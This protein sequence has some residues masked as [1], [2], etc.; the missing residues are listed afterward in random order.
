MPALLGGADGLWVLIARHGA[1]RTP[2]VTATETSDG[3][4]AWP[5][6]R[7][8]PVANA[9][10]KGGGDASLWVEALARGDEAAG[11]PLSDLVHDELRGLARDFL[12][13]ERGDHTLQATALVHEAWIRL[14]DQDR[15][16]WQGRSHFFA[17]AALAMR[18]VLVD[19]ARARMADRRGGGGKREPLAT[20][21]GERLSDD[22]SAGWSQDDLLTL[23][24]GLGVLA[25]RSAR[26]ARIVELRF[27]G[28]MTEKQVA[29]VL[30]LAP[31]TVTLE[32]KAARAWLS[33]WMKRGDE[34]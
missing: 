10:D 12:S 28:G 26:A 19:H 14:V 8:V 24:D 15:V 9:G 27:F 16:S 31:S 4:R 34:A 33:A 13:R 32:W 29:E 7:L 18:R 3:R 22:A 2:A 21:L 17:V 25:G 6:V 1:V 23:D 11:A 20:E 5:P 30:G